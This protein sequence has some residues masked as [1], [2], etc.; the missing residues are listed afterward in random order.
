M[1]AICFRGTAS[2]KNV[3]HDLQVLLF[4]PSQATWLCEAVT[5]TC[6]CFDGIFLLLLTAASED[7]QRGHAWQCI[8]ARQQ[9]K[10]LRFITDAC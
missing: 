1:I 5:F 3:L 6:L 8:S 7:L 9:L 2:M 4:S 10:A